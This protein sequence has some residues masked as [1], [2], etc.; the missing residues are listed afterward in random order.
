VTQLQQLAL[1]R[2]ALGGIIRKRRVHNGCKR[3]SRSPG[4]FASGEPGGAKRWASWRVQRLRRY[5]A[6]SGWM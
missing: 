3:R 5:S 6:A 1:Q 2:R 4:T